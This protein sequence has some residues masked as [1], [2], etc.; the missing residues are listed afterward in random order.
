MVL[1]LL[2]EVGVLRLLEGMLLPR[3]ALLRVL[4]VLLLVLNL[5]RLV[6]LVLL[7]CLLEQVWVRG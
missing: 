4:P 2:G 3:E 1:R 7:V 5:L 6:L